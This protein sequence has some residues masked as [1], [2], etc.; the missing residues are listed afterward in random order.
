LSYTTF[1]YANFGVSSDKIRMGEK[2]R[3]SVDVTN[4]GNMEAE[5]VVQLYV[6][7]LTASL[8]RPVK[9]LKG[10]Q[11]I[12]LKPEETKTVAFDLDSGVL[13]FHDIGMKY[14]VEPG[15]FHLWIGGDS[16]ADLMAEFEIIA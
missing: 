7:D 6:R 8:T 5:E 2:I 16:Q 12:R 1:T 13:G 14:V 11:R 9:E 15:K 10:F 4:A 3:A